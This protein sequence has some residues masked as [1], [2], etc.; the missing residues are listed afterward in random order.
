MKNYAIAKQYYCPF[1]HS[2]MC[3]I[4]SSLLLVI[5]L[6]QLTRVNLMCMLLIRI[7]E[8]GKVSRVS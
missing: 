8:G 4:M 2:Y 7:L 3:N 1:I 6:L 5:T